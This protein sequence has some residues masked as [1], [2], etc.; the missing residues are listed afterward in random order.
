MC[1][2]AP[3][4]SEDALGMRCA[5]RQENNR[6][7]GPLYASGA[8]VPRLRRLGTGE[9][10]NLRFDGVFADAGRIASDGL[11]AYDVAHILAR[12]QVARHGLLDA[13]LAGVGHVH[14]NQSASGA[15]F[16]AGSSRNILPKLARRRVGSC[17]F[18]RS[19]VNKW[20]VAATREYPTLY[21]FHLLTSHRGRRSRTW[22]RAQRASR[23]RAPPAPRG[24]PP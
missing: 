15:R 3:G 17:S 11:I 14:P 19:V 13:A 5:S 7:R 1:V 6:R 21:S 10:G 2:R 12:S 23:R 20:L 22:P 16:I 18:V 24:Q 9:G 8:I 4:G